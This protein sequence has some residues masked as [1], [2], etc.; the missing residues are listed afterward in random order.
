MSSNLDVT[1]FPFFKRVR[2]VGLLTAVLGVADDVVKAVTMGLNIADLRGMLRGDA[3][4]RPNP[5]LT[6]HADGFWMHMRP[7]YYNQA[8][9]GLY[10]TFR[11]GFLSV[12]F[13]VVE[14]ITGLFLMVFY[15]PSTRFAYTNMLNILSNVPL[16]KLMRDMHRLGAEAMVIIVA[17]HMLRTFVTASYK[18]P[19]QFTW[20]TGVVLLIITLAF[21]YT[22]YLLPWDQLAYWAVTIGASMAEAA[23]PP[24]VGQF[25]NILLKGAPD[26]GAS[27]LLRF[28]LLHVFALPLI[29]ASFLGIHYY[30]VVLHGH[31][32]PPGHEKSGEDTAKRVSPNVRR[33]YLPDILSSEVLWI[34]VVLL[35]MVITVMF[36]FSAPLE[37]QAN[38][39]STPLHTVAPW[40]F[41][42]IQGLLKLGDKTLMG[43]I[44]PT[45]LALSFLVMPYFDVGPFRHYGRR[46]VAISLSMLFITGI[47]VSSWMGTPAFLVQT[48]LDQ[49]ILFEI[50]PSER[51]GMIQRVPYDE[52]IL[53]AY[54]VDDWEESLPRSSGLWAVM[55]RYERLIDEARE[56]PSSKGG[57]PNAEAFLVIDQLQANVKGVTFRITWDNPENPS[58]RL[59][60]ELLVPIHEDAYPHGIGE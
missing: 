18:K 9:T 53:G 46:R 31:S 60:T 1:Q 17:L 47:V 16:G 32:L 56:T 10:P 28:Y 4:G 20:A 24:I 39:Q 8:V 26:L 5:R 33:Y 22:G 57:L 3:P 49:E 25:V 55:R 51:E 15:T 58:E 13:F 27:G 42:W 59:S 41:L 38:P 23:P 44:I 45:I 2:E 12:F 21:S 14:V 34:A 7:G 6:P 54:N 40:Y 35:M 30:K 37:N 36:F 50:A 19:R 11:L 43:V 29:G 52:L 48:T